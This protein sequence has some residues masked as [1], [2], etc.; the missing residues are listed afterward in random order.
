[1]WL[2]EQFSQIVIGLLCSNSKKNLLDTIKSKRIKWLHVMSVLFRC[3]LALY[4]TIYI[5]IFM[6]S[7]AFYH[8]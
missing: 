5:Y 8:H 2:S 6:Q 7:H 1:M 3:F 4:Y